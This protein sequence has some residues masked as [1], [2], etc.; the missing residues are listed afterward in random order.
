LNY[1]ICVATLLNRSVLIAG[2][3]PCVHTRDSNK[4]RSTINLPCPSHSHSGGL[5]VDNQI[6]DIDPLRMSKLLF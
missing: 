1:V 5:F 2:N 6:M 3:V 4:F